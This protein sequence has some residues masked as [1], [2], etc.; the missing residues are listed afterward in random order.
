[1]TDAPR[2]ADGTPE[3]ADPAADPPRDAAA[4]SERAG[5]LPASELLSRSGTR[6]RRG[7]GGTHRSE[8][9]AV[10]DGAT[11]VRPG[12]AVPVGAIGTAGPAVRL[13]Q[14]SPVSG[15]P[16]S[17]HP[18]LNYSGHIAV[19]LVSTFVLAVTGV[20]WGIQSRGEE[21][22]RQ[23]S[24]NAGL[25]GTEAGAA[26]GTP[27]SVAGPT[28]AYDA[29]NFLLVGSDS[30]AGDNAVEGT[31]DGTLSGNLNTDSMILLHI[32]ADRQLISAV[33]LPRDLWADAVPCNAYDR[34]TRSYGDE[35]EQRF[36]RLHLNSFYAV[37]GPKC[38]VDGVEELT[39][40][41]IT[42]FIEIGF[43]GFETM[44]DSLGGVEINACGPIVDAELQT[45]VAT[46]GPQT[47]T[48]T[49]ALHLSRARKVIGDT[50][51]DL[52]RIHRQQLILSAIL[53]KVKSTDVLLS[54]GRLGGFVEAFT[55]STTTDGVDFEVLMQLAESLGDF[56]P[57]K[58]TFYTLPTVPDPEDTSGRGSL[59]M[60][61]DTAVPL[62][63]A[64]R[65]DRPVPG[66]ETPPAEPAPTTAA[67]AAPVTS[68]T[69][70][71]ADVS[72]KVINATG[73]AGVATSAAAAL[74]GLGFTVPQDEL[75]RTDEVET[76]I[77]VVYREGDEAAA[78]T[79]AAA[80]EGA[81]LTAADDIPQRIVVRLGSSF[82][83]SV[84]E[85][86][87][88]DRIPAALLAQVPEG[89][90]GNVRPTTEAP[91]S[92][93]ATLARVNASDTTCF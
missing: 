19:V 11:P 77:T 45:L 91:A 83:G 16:R 86:R 66:V 64:L 20:Y 2:N 88:G 17:R 72:V 34:D 4:H 59:L 23:R 5:A 39:G 21:G 67:P 15:P 71:P 89:S 30:R 43:N 8:T 57:S 93:T 70:E 56:D 1:M 26:D 68:L 44:V 53:R 35:L 49:Q 10:S 42:R 61:V 7:R 6:R 78:L 92:G 65:D 25:G 84:D 69:V 9:P 82:D 14:A 47:I 81:V 24:V 36:S 40:I 74:A 73:R 51:S 76:G 62:L 87:V 3:G 18:L 28:P 60:D 52:A 63:A 48:G 85:V 13:A 22:I 12:H 55:E 58:V 29:E 54:P 32:S 50:S 38:L 41:Q 80:F 90:A 79:V 33:S 37:G 46:G 75:S 31:D 27:T